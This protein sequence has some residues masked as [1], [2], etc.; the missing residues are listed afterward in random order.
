MGF[1]TLEHLAN[2]SHKEIERM[3]TEYQKR[4]NRNMK[5]ALDPYHG[6][7]IAKILPKIVEH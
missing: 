7:M 1:K 4:I 2:T 3:F 5:S 6:S